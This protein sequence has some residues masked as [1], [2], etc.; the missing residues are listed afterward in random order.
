MP[1][2]LAPPS[3]PRST[4]ALC[5]EM[6]RKHGVSTG[7]ALDVGCAVGGAAFHLARDFAAVVGIDFSHAFVDASNH[8]KVR[9]W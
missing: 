7:R 3:P 5:F 1:L 6:C 9:A 4:A 2:G 8:M